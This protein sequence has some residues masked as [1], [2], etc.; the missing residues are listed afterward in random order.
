MFED[1]VGYGAEKRDEI[2]ES[3][4]EAFSELENIRR[5]TGKYMPN[6]LLLT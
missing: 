1:I 3:L 2:R 6:W 5:I 4:D